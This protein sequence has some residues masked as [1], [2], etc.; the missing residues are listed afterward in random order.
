M[1]SVF[2]HQ[3]AQTAACWCI[4]M[5]LFIDLRFHQNS[6]QIT[7]MT[8]SKR[9]WK[10]KRWNIHYACT[11]W[12]ANRIALVRLRVSCE[13]CNRFTRSVG[14]NLFNCLCHVDEWFTFVRC[15]R[16]CCVRRSTEKFYK[17]K[18]LHAWKILR[19]FY[20]VAAAICNQFSGI[21]CDRWTLSILRISANISKCFDGS[22]IRCKL[23][24]ANCK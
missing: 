12:M 1:Y 10:K 22:T 11:L 9:R 19:V 24:F 23:M 20:V 17:T 21:I 2:R 4:L 14:H 6:M 3:H 13:N 18:T 16:Q 8:I 7:C 5:S 15:W